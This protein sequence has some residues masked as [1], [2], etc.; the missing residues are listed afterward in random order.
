MTVGSGQAELGAEVLRGGKG[1]EREQIQPCAVGQQRCHGERQGAQR[2]E[3]D[4]LWQI[5][6]GPEDGPR[7]GRVDVTE[8][9]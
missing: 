8:P 1:L 7:H 6:E 3:P 2:H 9:P 5:D 4:F